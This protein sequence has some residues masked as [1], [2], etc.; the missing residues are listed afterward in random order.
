MYVL[1]PKISPDLQNKDCQMSQIFP[2]VA[3][4][5]ADEIKSNIFFL[6]WSSFV[7]KNVCINLEINI[8]SIATG[9]CVNQ[10]MDGIVDGRGMKINSAGSEVGI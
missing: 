9:K 1:N 4:E 10:G 3:Q 8:S 2:Y 6:K 5:N 7:C